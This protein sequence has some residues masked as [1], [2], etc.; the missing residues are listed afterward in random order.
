MLAIL[1]AVASIYIIAFELAYFNKGPATNMAY[2]VY[3]DNSRADDLAYRVFYPAYWLQR[4]VFEG[5]KHNKDRL[6]ASPL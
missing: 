3:F 4:Q 6:P 2:F 5:P 1:G